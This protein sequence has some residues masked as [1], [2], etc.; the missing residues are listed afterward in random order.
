VNVSESNGFALDLP[1][2]KEDLRVRVGGQSYL[3]REMDDW[4]LDQWMNAELKSTRYDGEGK[5]LGKDL[6]GR[7]TLMISLCL[8]TADGESRVPKAL[9]ANWGATTLLKL[10]DL[11]EKHND[12][13]KQ[14]A[15]E[16]EGKG[17]GGGAES[18]GTSASPP[19]S[20]GASETSSASAS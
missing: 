3:I 20:G 13:Q 2:G 15:E 4:A 1:E 18:T 6:T 16:R 11:C 7:T 5:F 17:S 19:A 14:K 10:F 12:L 8:F 9:V